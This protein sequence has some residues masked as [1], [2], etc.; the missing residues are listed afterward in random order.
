MLDTVYYPHFLEENQKY[1]L[2]KDL[3]RV[4]FVVKCDYSEFELVTRR[5]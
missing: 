5:I 3:G 4:L 2:F 1:L